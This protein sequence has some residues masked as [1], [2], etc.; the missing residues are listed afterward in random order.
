MLSDKVGFFPLLPSISNGIK[1]RATK[2]GEV[3]G[4]LKNSCN[5]KGIKDIHKCMFGQ[6]NERSPTKHRVKIVN[7]LTREEWTLIVY[8]WDRSVILAIL[9]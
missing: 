4:F 7:F 9:T 5:D 3:K 6:I 1:Y 2:C 8:M